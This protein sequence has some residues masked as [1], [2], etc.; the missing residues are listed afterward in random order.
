MPDYKGNIS[1]IY[2]LLKNNGATKQTEADF[3]KDMTDNPNAR[4]KVYGQ[5][6]KWG[7]SGIGNGYN[8][9]AKMVSPNAGGAKPK[10]SA[11]SQQAAEVGQTMFGGG[12]ET[13]ALQQAQQQV[14]QIQQANKEPQG[15]TREHLNN[16]QMQSLFGYKNMSNSRVVNDDSLWDEKGFKRPSG[17]PSIEEGERKAKENIGDVYESL[18]NGKGTRID[19]KGR[20]RSNDPLAAL[21]QER[22]ERNAKAADA[23][24]EEVKNTVGSVI[25]DADKRWMGIYNT[26]MK[27]TQD[28]MAA[29]HVANQ[30]NDPEK[31]LEEVR[32]KVSENA[33]K[34]IQ[35][36]M[37]IYEKAAKEEGV[38][39][40][41]YISKYV[42]PEISA[43]VEQE[44]DNAQMSRYMPQNA[45]E[46]IVE[47]LQDSIF[48]TLA[49]M[50]VTTQSQR[51]YQQRATEEAGE[52]YGMGAR[53]ARMGVGFAGD[54][55]V[56][57]GTGKLANTVISKVGLGS[58]EKTVGKTMT[59]RYLNFVNAN[60]SRAERF[61]SRAT[62]G[63]AHGA[64][65]MGAY[66]GIN[67]V[68]Q[69]LNNGDTSLA[70]LGAA[71]FHG[72]RHGVVTGVAM[73]G[74]GSLFG[75]LGSRLGARPGLSRGENFIRATDKAAFQMLGLVGEGFSMHLGEQI[76]SQIEGT[77]F[78]L[79]WEGTLE[80]AIMAGVM[81]ISSPSHYKSFKK[82]VAS[83]FLAEPKD[84]PIRLSDD[85][86][87]EL[88]KV[89]GSSSMEEV[90]TKIFPDG[91]KA[92]GN[93]TNAQIT[94]AQTRY[95]EMM[96]SLSWDAQNKISVA[97]TGTACS[98]RP[99]TGRFEANG[100]ILYE[101]ANDGT[102]LSTHEFKNTEEKNAY[103]YQKRLHQENVDFWGTYGKALLRDKDA[104]ITAMTDIARQNGVQDEFVIKAMEK[105]PIRRTQGEREVLRQIEEALHEMAFPKGEVHTEQ[106][107]IDGEKAAQ[108]AEVTSDEPKAEVVNN[109]NV[110]VTQAMADFSEAMKD[111]TWKEDYEELKKQGMSD[112]DIYNTLME[113][114]NEAE[115]APLADYVNAQAKQQGFMQG[116]AN[117]IEQKTSEQTNLVTSGKVTINGVERTDGRVITLVDADGNIVRLLSGDFKLN[118]DGTIETEQPIIVSDD[119]GN[120][121]PLNSVDGWKVA[122]STDAG[123]YASYIRE[124]LGQKA[125]AVIDPNGE[126]AQPAPTE[127]PKAETEVQR[128]E[129][130]GTTEAEQPQVETPK[131][132]VEAPKAE[133][134]QPV[135]E[136]SKPAPQAESKPTETKKD[137]IPLDENGKKNYVAD[138]V[139]PVDAVNDIYNR[140]VFNTEQADAY[141][142]SKI[143]EARKAYDK[144]NKDIAPKKGEDPDDYLARLQAHD[145]EVTAAKQVL[146]RWQAIYDE[147]H[148]FDAKEE[149]AEDVMKTDDIDMRGLED[150]PRYFIATNM[151]KITPESFNEQVGLGAREKRAMPGFLA[152]KEN[153]GVSIFEATDHIMQFLK[154]QGVTVD[155]DFVKNTIID[156]LT[157]GGPRSYIKN[158][159][160]EFL[161]NVSREEAYE[162]AKMDKDYLDNY[163]M[164][165]DEYKDYLEAERQ[166]VSE[167]YRGVDEDAL[168]AF[169]AEKWQ[170]EEEAVA[171]YEADQKEIEETLNSKKNGQE[172]GRTETGDGLL[173]QEEAHNEGRTGETSDKEGSVR[174][175]RGVQDQ[176]GL[177]PKE[178]SGREAV[179]NLSLEETKAEIDRL[180][181]ER[182]MTK[183][184]A[185]KAEIQKQIEELQK[186]GE[187]IVNKEAAD[188]LAESGIKEGDVLVP[189][190]GGDK[191]TVKEIDGHNVV[192]EQ[193][194]PYG[195]ETKTIHGIYIKENYDKAEK[196]DGFFGAAVAKAE[197]PKVDRLNDTT[198]SAEER[199][200][201]EKPLTEQEID[202]LPDEL[203]ND[204]VKTQIRSALEK[205]GNG[206]K[207]SALEELFYLNAL[208][209]VRTTTERGA[210]NSTDANGAQ[211]AD[212]D[213][214]RSSDGG[215]GGETGNVAGERRGETSEEQLRGQDSEGD[216]RSTTGVRGDREVRG[217]EPADDG[218]SAT[219]MESKP[220]SG[221]GSNG[222]DVRK[223]GGEAVSSTV[224]G[225]AARDEIKSS[226][227]ARKKKLAELAKR[228]KKTPKDTPPRL[229][230]A[231]SALGAWIGKQID[232]VDFV[233][234][235][236][237]SKETM[238][239]GGDY[240][241]LGIHDFKEW[242][243]RVKG[244]LGDLLK[245]TFDWKDAEVDDFIRE[246]WNSKYE[247]DG[248]THTIA[249]W[250]SI[251]G[252]RELRKEISRSLDE[253]RQLQKDVE[254][255][256]VKVG[257]KDNID[258][259]LPF[260]LPEQR[261]DVLKAETAFFGE[262]HQDRTH[263][264]GKG[265][266]FTNGTGTGK[267][268]TG[269]GIV[270]RFVKQG[271]GRVLI[272]TPSQP[273]VADWVKDG[274][275]LGL[276]VT[277]LENT[278]D[279][280]NGVVCT[281]YAN[282]R[283]N[284]A[285][286]RDTFDLI[287]YD[288][289]HKIMENKKGEET[290]G[291][292][293]HYQLSNKNKQHAVERVKMK[294]EPFRK[295]KEL[296]QELDDT[297]NIQENAI[298]KLRELDISLPK[299]PTNS[300]EI[301]EHIRAIE[302]EGENV[303][304]NKEKLNY[305]RIAKNAF[306]R[307]GEIPREIEAL[308]PEQEKL[309]P[310][311]EKEAEEAVKR[312]KSVFLSAT[313]FNTR[314]SLKYAEG[315]LFS[316]PEEN[317]NTVGTYN[318]RSPEQAF[319]E[320]HFSAGYRWR[321]GRLEQHM[322][323]AEALAKQEVR[324]SDYLQDQLGT[325][326][327]RQ[328]D[329]GYDYSRTFPT[330]T[331]DKAEAFN[332]ALQDV[333]HDKTMQPLWEAFHDVF[334]DYNKQTALFE[335]MKTALAAER[336]REHLARGRKVV[337]FH[338]RRTTK[339]ELQ[340]PFQQALTIAK[341]NSENMSAKDKQKVA[342]AIAAFHSKYGDLLKWEQ[343]LD[344]R[345]PREQLADIFGEDKVAFFSGE[346]TTKQKNQSIDDFMK[347]N[348]GKD[349]IVI[350][351]ASGKEG[352]S[353]HDQTGEH[354]RVQISLC[355]PQSPIAF[356]QSEG[357]IYRIGQKSNAVFE[358]PLLGLNL[359][360]NLWAHKFNNALGT[361]EYLAMG[362]K[363][364]NL[365]ESIA[366]G[367]ME[368]SGTIGFDDAG[369]GGKA[370]DGNVEAHVGTGFDG[371]ITDYFTNQKIS[372]KRENREGADYFPTPEPVGYKMVEWAGLTEGE[373][374]LEPSAGHG[375]IARYVPKSN[376]LTMIEPSQSLMSKLVL[377]TPGSGRK[378]EGGTFED[379]NVINK[380][381]AIVMNPP[382]GAGGT[383]AVEHVAKGFKHL[384]EGGRLI[385]II[386][387]GPA[388]DKKM[389]KWL[390]SKD[391]ES[392][393]I[394]GEI[395]LPSCTF[396]RA[397]TAVNTRIV[398][399]D[400]VTREEVRNGMPT[401]KEVDLRSVTD[402][403]ELF[404]KMRDIDMP[405][406]TI[407][408][409]YLR[410]KAAKNFR[411]KIADPD[412]AN[413]FVVSFVEANQKFVRIDFKRGGV[414][415]WIDV[416]EIQNNKDEALRSYRRI[417][418][419]YDTADA[420]FRANRI[421]TMGRGSNK[422][423]IREADIKR[424][425]YQNAMEFVA[426]VA[427]TTVKELD[428]RNNELTERLRNGSKPS[429][430]PQAEVK[431]QESRWEYSVVKHTQT[432]ADLHI[433]KSKE[434]MTDEEYR[435][436]LARAKELGGFYDRYSKGFR[437]ETKE[438]ADKFMQQ[439]GE[440]RFSEELEE[441]TV[442]DTEYKKAVE[443]GDTDSA[444]KILSESFKEA[445]PDTKV[446]DKDGNPMIV[447]HGSPY[448][449][450]TEFD[451][452]KG[453]S[454]GLKEYGTYFTTNKTLAKMYK[455]GRKLTPELLEEI[456]VQIAKYENI[457][458]NAR[459]TREYD[460]A[461]AQI[462]ILKK[463]K[464]GKIYAC[465]LNVEHPKEF[466]AEGAD[467]WSGWNKL[468]QDVGY[469]V[470]KGHE[471]IEAIAGKNSA[472]VMDETYDGIIAH[473]IA[474]VHGKADAEL[475]GDAIL[476][477]KPEQIKSAEVEYDNN[478][479]LILPS[480]RFK[481]E[482][483]DI[484]FKEE[485]SEA[486]RLKMSDSPEKFAEQQQRAVEQNGIVMPGLN[487]VEV[488]I[489]DVPKHDFE[490]TGKE[491]LKSAE[492]WAKD[493]IVGTH[494]AT[495]SE[496]KTFEYK[497]GKK[498][499][500]KY[501]SSS[502]LEN[503]DNIGVHI[504]V[505]KKL[506][507]VIS[508]SIEAEVHPDYTKNNEGVRN[509]DNPI[510][511]KSLIHRFYGAVTIDGKTYRVKTTMK[512]YADINR[513]KNAYTYEVTKIELLEA[514]TLG[515]SGTSKDPVAMTSNN[516]ISG[517]KLLKDV[518]KEYDKGKKLLEQSKLADKLQSEVSKSEDK[519]T[520]RAHIDT[521]S[522]DLNTPC[523]V[524]NDVSTIENKKVR[525]AIE[526]GR[527]VKG[528]WDK[529]GVHLY[530][531]NI[532][533]RYDA[534]TT[535]LHET[536]GHD[537]LRKLM[538]GKDGKSRNFQKFLDMVW[539]DKKNKALHEFVKEYAPKNGWDLHEAVDEWL[540]REAEKP[541]TDE[542]FGMWGRVKAMFNN[543]LRALGFKSDMSLNDVRYAIWLSKR[544]KQKPN[545]PLMK[546]RAAAFRWG[547]EHS[548][549]KPA[550]KDGRYVE[551]NA[552]AVFGEW[553]HGNEL[554]SIVENAKAKGTYM[555]APNGQ[556][557]KL[558]ER[559]WAQ[560]RTQSFK[561]WF[562]DW[563]ND[564]ENAS[565]VVDEN[566]EPLVVY[567]GTDADFTVFDPEKNDGEHKCF[568]FTD[569]QEMASSYK[570]G[571]KL[572][573]VFL[574]IRD[575]YE[576]EGHGKWWNDV[577]LVPGSNGIEYLREYKKTLE[578]D[579]LKEKRGF[580]NFWGGYTVSEEQVKKKQDWL[581]EDVRAKLLDRY[582]KLMA[583]E[584]KTLL[585]KI[586]KVVEIKNI[587]RAA[588]RWSKYARFDYVHAA[589]R[590]I[591]LI[592]NDRDGIIFKDII[593]YGKSIPNPTPHDVFVVYD[594]KNIKS[595]T[596][597]VGT[598]SKESDDIRF[599]ASLTPL[600]TACVQ[601][602]NRRLQEESFK[603]HEA[604]TDNMDSLRELQE[605]ISGKKYY[606]IKDSE[607]AYI[608]ENHASSKSEAAWNKFKVQLYQPLEAAIN[609][610]VGLFGGNPTETIGKMEDYGMKKHGLE[611]NR[612]LFVRDAIEA[613]TD[614]R[615]K[616][617]MTLDWDNERHRLSTELMSGKID[618]REYLEGLDNFISKNIDSSYDPNKNDYSGISA[619]DPNRIKRGRK[620]EY[621]ENAIIDDV[622]DMETLLGDKAQNFW[623][624]VRKA[625]DFA[626][627]YSY[628]TGMID[629]KSQDHIK[630]MF[631]FYLPLR[632]FNEETME[633]V[634]DYIGGR[635]NGADL[636]IRNAKGRLSEAESPLAHIAKMAMTSIT[637]GEDNKVRQMFYRLV[638]NHPSDAAKVSDVW[639]V[640]TKDPVTGNETWEVTLP[641]IP[642][643]ATPKEIADIM[644]NF[645]ALMEAKKGSGEARKAKSRP[646]YGRIFE[647]KAHASQHIVRTSINGK[648]KMVYV[649]GNPR[650]AQALNGQLVHKGA[651][652]I[653]TKAMKWIASFSTS[654]SPEFILSNTS[655]DTLF[656]NANIASKES[657]AYYAKFT[658]NQAISGAVLS[659]TGI[660][661]DRLNGESL[662]E[663][664]YRG[665]IDTSKPMEKMFAEFMD[666]GGRTGFL[667]MQDV[668]K[669]GEDLKASIKGKRASDKFKQYLK[670]GIGL[671]PKSVEQM[672]MR[673]ELINRFATYM[674]SRQMG[675]S[676][677]RSVADA[678]EVSVNFNR[679]GAGN[680]GQGVYANIGYLRDYYMFYNAGIQSYETLWRNLKKDTSTAIRTTAFMGLIPGAL[681]AAYAMWLAGM[682]DE[683]Y[684]N[685]PSWDRRNNICIPVKGEGYIK[686]PLPIELR[687]FW[688]MGDIYASL[689]HK[690]L[691]TEESP[692]FAMLGQ[693]TQALPIDVLE[694][695]EKNL[696]DV[697]GYTW[698]VP[699][700]AR[701]L[702]EYAMNIDWKGAPIEKESK[703]NPD[704]PRWTRA[705]DSTNQILV[706]FCKYAHNTFR[707]GKHTAQETD[708]T[709]DGFWIDPSLYDHLLKSYFGG[710]YSIFGKT[711][712]TGINAVENGEIDFAHAPMTSRVWGGFSER[713]ADA[714]TN[715]KF[716][717]YKREADNVGKEFSNAENKTNPM[718]ITEL[719]E[720]SRGKRYAI[721]KSADKELQRLRKIISHSDNPD[722][723][724]EAERKQKELRRDLVDALDN[725]E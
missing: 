74:V 401:R 372:A 11:T 382:Y 6:K 236:E 52:K 473:N 75:E 290:I 464:E 121:R 707:E 16:P 476:V 317:K 287:V 289:S 24:R 608:A 83:M 234:V 365:S 528:W 462:D 282:L 697:K 349:I 591:D 253:K 142:Q 227:E 533:S 632:G 341:V 99:R 642:T 394:T 596:R 386:P 582:D 433:V 405:E 597:N 623:D 619:Y 602:Y 555:K 705:Y 309:M 549:Y 140:G 709:G 72:I 65:N 542:N 448:G 231:A 422:V 575:I 686:I 46:F 280:G 189:K 270:K 298:N 152:K 284:E 194:K 43:Q 483:S 682:D 26:Q 721:Y 303:E 205:L 544:M 17:Q 498:S 684:S 502:S 106:S 215:E 3:A 475:M 186:H 683:E 126:F 80:N 53:L 377:N 678:K 478:G 335:T 612:K 414:S 675:R 655:R 256:E 203:F 650:A 249:E 241:R 424:D 156:I 263:G 274:Q 301:D 71:F 305:L 588:N 73:G 320:Q 356:I 455:E 706:E 162:R 677:L 666:N 250:A 79:T 315:Y 255:I 61:A 620:V 656:A 633:D 458:E 577:G 710:A 202:S 491:V 716:W 668:D 150:D 135:A 420:S 238:L 344:Y 673:A 535:I 21:Q 370:Y 503:S 375:A 487:E 233:A 164:E 28:P 104:V 427:G 461:Q 143:E 509:A 306:N 432:G 316:Y 423:E 564:P 390:E 545:D 39:T 87:R 63:M 108:D 600:H 160:E 225:E 696:A 107:A 343:G 332:Q 708:T 719:K 210:E 648:P 441:P 112:A 569:S 610:C 76:N 661:G 165:Y 504:A 400:K 35:S 524:H 221:A 212:G 586:K 723:V 318:H 93:A 211:L 2:T 217:G 641:D 286:L 374:A 331:L 693:V 614:A 639:E 115:L 350:Q 415:L 445:F 434:R 567:H 159:R 98:A 181:D 124:L 667:A 264:F 171:K 144:V 407:D 100:N 60:L 354:Q 447:F 517:A 357:R 180:Q 55:P 725:V 295:E 323:N 8:D 547:M 84:N 376:N 15:Q 624:A 561:E 538:N 216:I 520:V 5:L 85:D 240:L 402:V 477:F 548:N 260:L 36:N 609:E 261:G 537:G 214:A 467:G 511:N 361:T 308:K 125:T 92:E 457:L 41:E 640:K 552:K 118:E 219:G 698:I 322:E 384:N 12:E 685:I 428:T 304:G 128:N 271:K 660:G 510:N 312:T 145:A 505:L 646:N 653:A 94:E 224:A 49:N 615:A 649:L 281:T 518:E 399:I 450:I 235:G 101:Y 718:A 689:K 724:A 714:T 30:E 277:P 554:T 232:S 465:Y 183:D 170:E 266:M 663:K 393:V 585:D 643:D 269:L 637:R 516:S 367:I 521:V 492:K 453:A 403:N 449:A 120:P 33:T 288:E 360:I 329:N 494:T 589:T 206:D 488:K 606:D 618:Y 387:D 178:A 184:E 190:N 514:P 391:A 409:E 413:K 383:T 595:A 132:E 379:Y 590:D 431:P 32:S 559:Q 105:E 385:A 713:E 658:K 86:K 470:K 611:R 665:H 574:N 396:G 314:E 389:Q 223:S 435:K 137:G 440:T 117:E 587:E 490:G 541:V 364:R 466:D 456:D 515:G 69:T 149:E 489:V 195:K 13:T 10:P 136:E 604:N 209:H 179:E 337:V 512:E 398:V 418:E 37:A 89:T 662:F 340:N 88:M 355:L 220:S 4:L 664:Y 479:R 412:S 592:Y 701:P 40:E 273:K 628:E 500:D 68:V 645:E 421:F 292:A 532:H 442:R 669:L 699:T 687:A 326:S 327:T 358:Y 622:M 452:T 247:M 531:P 688:G 472:A 38:T 97:L 529:D 45:G 201:G 369:V 330:V 627:D 363:A 671:I 226:I 605:L 25:A 1:Q 469:D 626:V 613:I 573:P 130:E 252:D 644:D 213:N 419:R 297:R 546:A 565:K 34:M 594:A 313:P 408:K 51:Q 481:S 338:R 285:V 328:I 133:P 468:T 339:D 536:V 347:D 519:P 436:E 207:L 525:K 651:K 77:G 131:A 27:Y 141:V 336:I 702:A 508:N 166:R 523:E 513:A 193:L 543:A 177:V 601:E 302:Q 392:A 629:S 599:S 429:E 161:A 59:D 29:I 311:I 300:A 451:H 246:M 66:E 44:F 259:T 291:T 199:I 359:E 417:K 694:A 299:H 720:S 9:F 81:K 182:D 711:L 680:A 163:G 568:Y 103:V 352:I 57:A 82:N 276:E 62:T 463:A 229:Y 319:L 652:N 42:M 539:A 268:Y 584:P 157:S 19:E 540:A 109:T 715:A 129:S 96:N 248:E 581:N 200:K 158:M 353:L 251:L 111:A 580:P 425:I 228:I 110:E 208:K 454:S 114:Y 437:F 570:G 325:L 91:E 679:K 672:N 444:T 507:E 151:L 293:V 192:I 534:E 703:F 113:Q 571:S 348:K 647:N 670:M 123:E 191:I 712:N 388:C 607:N 14:Q 625:T 173:H 681:G 616:Q 583:S 54:A 426:K 654:Y 566:G 154:D 218:V 598:Y 127:T 404:E 237:F 70:G 64:I 47:G 676:I 621:D 636:P 134:Q 471:A 480:E 243:K 294:Y 406:R 345:L 169:R 346:E 283:A 267:T 242:A 58:I 551:E 23:T 560:V 342:D 272:V 692:T 438:N 572:M 617:Q 78:N 56:F 522:K 351:E 395:K 690:R 258:Q 695:G 704:A 279:A 579:V 197:T 31:V 443:E 497:I 631:D 95:L 635:G 275:N 139:R 691:Q 153:G 321:Y 122:G 102:L 265:M 167:L 20:L 176:D 484:R 501:V 378:Y 175:V 717:A 18:V 562:G 563:E 397:G 506:P 674:T 416:E 262:K 482:N 368:N 148:K 700:A 558:K 334:Y 527:K 362:S 119:N 147:A 48:G 116:V 146:D 333:F 155:E 310:E 22:S 603:L 257:D 172:T 474:D 168:Y 556:P 659:L 278:K 446:V 67:G 366:K 230:D 307:L 204:V 50:A 485:S 722:K 198:L 254:N 222:S 187:K 381:D 196:G 324:F 185:K 90:M 188:Y 380:H 460:A 630:D 550:V 557:T 578:A 411:R 245:D 499:I 553:T 493:N 373:S 239:L 459:N 495:D 174:P 296:R 371:A 638:A 138:G 634:Y 439:E 576:M 496:G 410:E 593:D 7:T 486:E 657:A 244:E 526:S 430:Q 530:M